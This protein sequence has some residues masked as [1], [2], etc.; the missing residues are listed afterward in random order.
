[1][2]IGTAVLGGAAGGAVVSV[3]INAID[4]VSPAIGGINK[5]LLGLG[6]GV[7]AFGI[8][9]AGA[10][11]MIVSEGAKLEQTKAKFTT[12]LGSGEAAT[13]MLKELADFAS[14]TPFTIPG[15]ENASGLLLAVGFNAEE[16]IPTLQFM[17][18]IAAGVG[19]DDAGMQSIIKNMGQIKTLGK[20]TTRELNDFAMRGIPIYDLLAEHMGKTTAEIQEMVTKG[21][22]GFNDVEAAMKGATQEGGK[23]F[24]AMEVQSK[25]F[26]GQVSN[27]QDSFITMARTMSE[28]FLPAVKFVAEKLAILVNWMGKNPKL[29]KFAAALLGIAT[30]AALIIG[31]LMIMIALKG[32]FIAAMGFIAAAI[33]VVIANLWWIVPAI[34]SAI[35]IGILLKE[36]WDEIKEAIVGAWNKIKPAVMELWDSLKLLWDSTKDLWGSMKELWSLMDGPVLTV[37]KILGG[38]FIGFL[39]GSILAV[40]FVLTAMIKIGTFVINKFTDIVNAGKNLGTNLKNTFISVANT[41]LVVWNRI[42]DV[43]EDSINKIIGMINDFLSSDLVKIGL[44]ALGIS[45]KQIQEVSFDRFKGELLK[46]EDF[47]KPQATQPTIIIENINGLTGKDIADS[48]Q[49]ELANRTNLG[50]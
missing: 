34:A 8:A 29:L 11:S 35:A 46:L 31:P 25:T 45:S 14:K 2:G 50:V 5:S 30:A 6:V 23:F 7:T 1:M 19:L 36:N 49:D 44:G 3:V 43:I 40:I 42:V 37:I 15:I 27:I 24:K 28:V 26:L 18:D 13:N 17:G 38:I 39:V 22:I 20:A 9:G 16:V 32:L 12:L 4:N 21:E 41:V 33:G 47:N 48:L 10:I